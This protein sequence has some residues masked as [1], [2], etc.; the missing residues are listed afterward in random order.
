MEFKIEKLEHCT[1][2]TIEASKLNSAISPELKNH[3]NTAIEEGK[4]N[5]L[6]L[7]ISNCEYCDSSG[8]SAILVGHRAAKINNGLLVVSGAKELVSKL[9]NLSK[10]D[11]ILSLTPSMPEALDLIM[12]HEIEKGFE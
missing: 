3:F 5:N 1:A 10:L 12:M 6:L 8:L 11:T 2:I 7:D 4:L 9:I